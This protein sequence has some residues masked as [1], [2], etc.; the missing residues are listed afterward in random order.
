MSVFEQKHPLISR[1]RTDAIP[2]N[3]TATFEIKYSK[4]SLKES[5]ACLAFCKPKIKT[6][7]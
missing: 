1:D 3:Q 6:E 7:Q 2:L 5:P 4:C